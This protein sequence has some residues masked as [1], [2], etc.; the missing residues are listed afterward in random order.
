M[1]I[2]GASLNSALNHAFF[3]SDTMDVINN[4][5]CPVIVI[6]Q[7]A[8]IKK[9]QKVTIATAF[10]IT[11]IN[12]INYVVKLSQQ[13]NFQ[14]EIV[15]V[16]ISGQSE[17]KT[18]VTAFRTHISYL[19]GE[20]VTYKQIKG[21]NVVDRLNTLCRE[22]GS[23]MLALIHYEH[24]FLSNVFNKCNT[25]QALYNQRLPLIIVPSHMRT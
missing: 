9:I 18:R 19:E 2:M 13:L 24:G 5:D 6:P 21:K 11:D 3:G 25:E 14:L 1:I 22:N 4:S 8:E 15:H 23:D 20:N 10:E 17:D 16:S 12:A 7:K